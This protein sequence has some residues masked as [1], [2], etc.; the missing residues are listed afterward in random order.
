MVRE[1]AYECLGGIRNDNFLGDLQGL[2][3]G[4]KN[5][6][7]NVEDFVSVVTFF[8]QFLLY[9]VRL[10]SAT[11]KAFRFCGFRIIEIVMVPAIFL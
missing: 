5:K 2:R 8:R 3:P 10:A 4:E 9:L 11:S 6:P 1:V 7:V